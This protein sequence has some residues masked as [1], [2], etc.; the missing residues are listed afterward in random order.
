LAGLAGHLELQLEYQWIRA[1]FSYLNSGRP[2]GEATMVL[3]IEF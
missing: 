3:L 2:C 1:I